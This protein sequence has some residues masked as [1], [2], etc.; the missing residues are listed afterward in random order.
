MLGYATYNSSLKEFST[1]EIVSIGHRKGRTQNNGR[2][3][4]PDSG[5][6]GFYFTLAKDIPSERIAPAFVDIYNADRLCS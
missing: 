6:I 3:N 2:Q 1:F 5:Y 4:S